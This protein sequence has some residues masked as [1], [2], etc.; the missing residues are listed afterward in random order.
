MENIAFK[1]WNTII[2]WAVFAIALITYTLTVEPTLSFWDCGEYI[3]TSAKLEVGHPPG[4]PLFQMLGAFFAMFATSDAQIALMVNMMS[5]FS[6]AFTILFLFWSSSLI[7]KRFIFKDTLDNNTTVLTL[8]ASAVGALAF[9]FS[10]SFWFNAVEAEVYAMAT[11]FISLL[12]WLGLRWEQN[13]HQPKGNRWLLLISLVIGLSFGV[14][15]MA[16]LTIPAI[17]FLYFF[18]NYK[19]LTW[20]NVLI[21]HVVIVAVLLFIFKLLL[22]YTMGYFGKM[23]I[24]MV[25]SLGMPFNS[26]TIF[27]FISIIALFWFGL[28]YTR[29]KDKPLANTLLLCVL[30]VLV[31]FSTW[32]MLPIRANAGTPINENKPSDAAEVLAYYNREQ[33]GEQQLFFGPMYSEIYS[34]LDAVT[35]Y[36]DEK[37]NYE[38]DYKTNT[39]IITNNFKNARQNTDDAHKGLMPRMWSTDHAVNYMSYTEPLNFYIHPDYAEEQQLVEIVGGFRNGFLQGEFDLDDYN[40]FLKSYGEYLVVEK[41]SLASNIQFMFEYQFG[42]MY[43]RYLMWNFVGRQND[44]Q[45]KG[46]L[47]NGNWLSGIPLVDNAR[48]GNQ[49]QITSDMKNNRGRNTYFFLPFILAIAGMLYHAKK[50]AKSFY[51]LLVLFLFTG[52]AL[53]VYLNER[54]FEVRERDYA[55]VGSFFVFAMWI[56]F[57]VLSVF[58]LIKKYLKPK[59]AAPAVV[60]ICLLAAP[61]LMATQN[62]DDHDRSGKDTALALAKTYLDSC[63]P[64]AILFTIGDNDTF[65]LWYAQEIENYRTDVRLVNTSL[66][67]TD[68]YIDQMKKKAYDSEGLPISLTRDKYLG[69][70]RNYSLLVEKTKDS[71]SLNDLITFVSFDDPKAKKTLQSGQEV[72]YYPTNKVF[73]PINKE[74]II[75]NKVVSQKYYDSIVPAM[76][77]EMDG[78]ALYKNRLIMLDIVNQNNWERPIYFT[79]GSFGNDDYLWMKE[80]LEMDGMVYKLVPV[81]TVADDKNP[82]PLNM[83]FID[84]DKMY[85]LVM[86]WDWGKSGSP[87]IYHDI[88][89][90]KNSISY[91]T[92]L[93]RLMN[94][95]ISEDKNAKAEKVIDLAMGKMPVEHFGYYTLV[96]PFAEGYYKIGKTEKA[97]AIV[98]KLIAKYQEDLTYYKSLSMGDQNG[99][100]REIVSKIEYYKELVLITKEYDT[101]FFEKEKGAFNHY[102]KMFEYYRRKNIE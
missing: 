88:E 81:K 60:G 93:T 58:D 90:R 67:N 61:V 101:A 78:H 9:T 44:E 54:P 39:Y 70:R 86:K 85:N 5:V 15:F 65:P 46:D 99:Y 55:L 59:I 32:I 64:N 92:N 3:A 24:F 45:G 62:W 42:Y 96:E 75:K 91:R 63:E 34:G 100:I 89:T 71:I 80:Y 27:A 38:R 29:K 52:L 30:F 17:G 74:N 36:L 6:S 94:Q 1:K 8:G 51:V 48:L 68:W 57:G 79:G 4:A 13:M 11:L 84:S 56:G 16:I 76:H 49:A 50:D 12:F 2:G 102:N 31:G 20:K 73:I 26:G 66:I 69:S 41:P 83:G 77:F 37:P 22:P 25:N 10:D 28:R 21:A 53:K 43:W 33:Y 7:M 95:L 47:Q 72:N 40:S 97:N 35:P 87:D 18:K 23:E 98:K 82:S 14:H 19:T